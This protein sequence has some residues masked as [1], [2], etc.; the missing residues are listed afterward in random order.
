VDA[1]AP[2][3][4]LALLEDW[5]P[6]D[7]E[8][9]DGELLDGFGPFDVELLDGELFDGLGPLDVELFDVELFDG[10]LFDGLGPLDVEL[11]GGLPLDD[12]GPFDG[13]EELDARGP[14]DEPCVAD[15]PPDPRPP[16]EPCCPPEPSASVSPVDRS[17]EA[18][19]ERSSS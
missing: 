13:F 19:T 4:E 1:L 17:A 12:F 16:D 18:C 6:L 7:V 9:F 14:R 10:E 5:G 11:F 8:L 3:D 15:G 2:G